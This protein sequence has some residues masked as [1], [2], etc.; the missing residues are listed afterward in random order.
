MRFSF[1]Y[2]VIGS[3]SQKHNYQE[4][5]S[6]QHYRI[7]LKSYLTCLSYNGVSIVLR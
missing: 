6:K 4:Q 2:L 1:C 3:S 5:F 7:T